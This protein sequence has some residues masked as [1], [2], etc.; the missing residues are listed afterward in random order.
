MRKFPLRFFRALG[1]P[2]LLAA[3]A[4]P[5]PAST[6]K[7]DSDV[8]KKSIRGDTRFIPVELWTG[9]GWDGAN[10]LNW[11][12]VDGQYRHLDIPDAKYYRIVGP[13][14]WEQPDG[15]GFR[16]YER[17]NPA[18][19]DGQ[20]LKNQKLQLFTLNKEKTGLGRVYDSR[21]NRKFSQG[22][23]F[24]LG[25]WTVGKTHHV[26]LDQYI[27]LKSRKREERITLTEIDYVFTIP[28]PAKE[29]LLHCIK[30]EWEVVP[31]AQET[32]TLTIADKGESHNYYVYCPCKSMVKDTPV[33]PKISK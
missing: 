30:F 26:S 18:V 21:E 8:W 33:R 29:K 11:P 24:P 3:L 23:K 28:I 12:A 17:T 22:I 5:L 9:T 25:Y 4:A 31:K 20:S 1:F 10:T 19:K 14:K 2:I 13:F 7:V 32:T 27:G 15:H 6:C 16:F